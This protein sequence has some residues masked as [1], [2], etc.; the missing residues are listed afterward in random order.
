[1]KKVLALLLAAALCLGLAACGKTP[2]EAENTEGQASLSTE[3]DTVGTGEEPTDG[4]AASVAA[5]ED[6]A[7]YWAAEDGTV[8][9]WE[10]ETDHL[11]G[12]ITAQFS[13]WDFPDT[14]ADGS[15]MLAGD[16]LSLQISDLV[17]TYALSQEGGSL[18]LRYLAEESTVTP[19][20]EGGYF[21]DLCKNFTVYP[22][23]SRQTVELTVDNWQE[24]FE[25]R[26]TNH[27]IRN[28][29]G[30]FESMDSGSWVFVPKKGAPHVIIGLENGAAE[31]NLQDEYYCW[32]TYDFATDAFTQGQPAS[33]EEVSGY[34]RQG[35]DQT[36][37]FSFWLSSDG[38]FVCWIKQ[39]YS[40]EPVATDSSYS[41]IGNA[42]R[43]VEM[44][45]I[46]GTLTVIS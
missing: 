34:N 31:V 14:L 37:D 29:F 28:S 20:F 18:S 8:L 35:E 36:R 7:G 22:G 16:R 39:N 41:Y 44:L 4:G 30:E 38:T 19:D 33:E 11:E 27:P 42:Y 3:A 46:Q 26:P 17:C 13:S 1:M 5:P 21:A 10:W 25:F 2:T 23:S 43:N 12:V 40:T 45:R 9:Q 32:Y 24:Y 15:P 6:L